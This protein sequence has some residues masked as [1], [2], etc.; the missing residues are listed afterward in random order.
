MSVP[1]DVDRPPSSAS[2]G[3]AVEWLRRRVA[4]STESGGLEALRRAAEAGV[5]Q[6]AVVLVG[7]ELVHGGS[8]RLSGLWR[9]RLMRSLGQAQRVA[10]FGRGQVG[11]GA[12]WVLD[13][14]A[15]GAEDPGLEAP[16]SLAFYAAALRRESRR[17]RRNARGLGPVP[18]TGQAQ[19]ELAREARLCRR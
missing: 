14:M 16:V 2:R 11:A 1:D 12:L 4:G 3:V 19:R 10:C 7:W 17:W 15:A 5:D 6:L 13:Q 18:D 8:P 9:D